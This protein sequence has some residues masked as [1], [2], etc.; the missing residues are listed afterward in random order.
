MVKELL[1]LIF[2]S[3]AHAFH[4]PRNW[5][6]LPSELKHIV[7]RILTDRF[8]QVGISTGSRDDFYAK[9]GGTKATIEGFASS[10]RATMRAVRETGYRILYYMSFLGEHFYGY[11]ELPEPLSHALF[12]DACALSTHQMAVLVEMIRPLID[13]CPASLRGHFLPPF[14]SALFQQLDR[15]ASTE[16]DRMDQR[17]ENSSEDDNLAD[18]MRDESI[19][20]QLTFTS[21]MVVAGLLDPTKAGEFSNIFSSVYI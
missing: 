9:V 15:K 16:W 13:N 19:L 5:I 17:L 14:L 2:Y 21:V 11:K 20:R 3:Q 1:G 18:E 8:W 6:E 4:D 12:H 10:I 7:R